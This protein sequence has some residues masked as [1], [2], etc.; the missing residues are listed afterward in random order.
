MRDSLEHQ[1]PGVIV[2]DFTLEPDGEIA[3]PTIELD[4]KKSKL[5]RCSVSMLMEEISKSL[6]ASFEMLIVHMSAKSVQ[7]LA[8][9][10]TEV[11]E[12]TEEDQKA[13]HVRF[14]YC[15]YTPDGRFLPFLT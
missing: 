11:I 13:R 3:P 5:R 10:E 8:G 4:F 14:G 1:L 9:M 7:K 15:A 12:L 2:R 6:L